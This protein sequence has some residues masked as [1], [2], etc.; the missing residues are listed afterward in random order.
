MNEW[1]IGVGRNE[2]RNERKDERKNGEKDGDHRIGKVYGR[3]LHWVVTAQHGQYPSRDNS[4]S[5][6]IPP[7]RY[8]I[9]NICTTTAWLKTGNKETALAFLFGG[10]TD[11]GTFAFAFLGV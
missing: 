7:G 6:A 11:K 4:I 2:R 9:D 3:T 5:T 10:Q 8:N 1:M